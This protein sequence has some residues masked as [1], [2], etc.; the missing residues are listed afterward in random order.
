[1]SYS[2]PALSF[3]NNFSDLAWVGSYVDGLMASSGDTSYGVIY[4]WDDD[5]LV[6]W[7]PVAV[8]RRCD[9]KWLRRLVL[10]TASRGRGGI[11]WNGL[12]LGE[13]EHVNGH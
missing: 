12:D 8:L 9:G 1:M 7:P 11:N 3:E 4:E 2:I 6:D 10:V 13:E 5:A